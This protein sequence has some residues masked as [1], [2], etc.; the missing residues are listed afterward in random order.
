MAQIKPGA[1]VVG[2]LRSSDPFVVPIQQRRAR[3][4]NTTGFDPINPF[5]SSIY[6]T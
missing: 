3:I 4:T 6:S 2:V 1:P 5:R